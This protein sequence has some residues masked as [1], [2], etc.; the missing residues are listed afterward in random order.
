MKKAKQGGS[1]SEQV[2]LQKIWSYGVLKC[3]C[4]VWSMGSRPLRWQ[5]FLLL[6]CRLITHDGFVHLLVELLSGDGSV[7]QRVDGINHEVR[8]GVVVLLQS[9]TVAMGADGFHDNLCSRY[10]LLDVAFQN[11]GHTKWQFFFFSFRLMGTQHSSAA[12]PALARLL[13]DDGVETGADW[14]SLFL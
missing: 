12:A 7:C 2:W 5:N 6:E 9:I 1:L 13:L 10:L 14:L 3:F 8:L 11:A 4:S